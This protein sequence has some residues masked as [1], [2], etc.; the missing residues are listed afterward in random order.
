MLLPAIR[1][2]AEWGQMFTD[3]EQWAAAV[4]AICHREGIPCR[5][6]EAGYPGTNAVYIVDR[7][8]VVKV[9]APFCHADYDLECTLYPLLAREPQIP[10]PRLLARGTWQDRIDWPYI[11][12]DYLPGQPIRE[13]WKDIPPGNR[14]DVADHLGRILRRLH[15][16][17]VDAI[18][19]PELLL[20][21]SASGREWRRFVRSRRLEFAQHFRQETALPSQIIDQCAAWIESV[22]DDVQADRLVLLNGDVT[23]DH[24]LVQRQD[25]LWRISGLIDFADALI[26]QVDY[27][28]IALWFGA[29]NGEAEAMRACMMAYRPAVQLDKSFVTRALAFTLL[30]QFGAGIVRSL[31]ERRGNPEVH[32]L[33]ELTDLLWG[34]LAKGGIGDV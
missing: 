34:N 8:Y 26:G 9:Y 10:A 7:T 27:E 29:L 17:P 30:H 12:M 31:L 24:V 18:Q 25:G 21:L 5:D 22:W 16:I 1:T 6:I 14:A 33:G 2:W 11:V 3:L 4:R 19:A 28:W 32:S 15:S 20:A 13:V 23:E